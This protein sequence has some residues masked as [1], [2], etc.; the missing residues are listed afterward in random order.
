[1]RKP[2]RVSRT[3]RQK[4]RFSPLVLVGGLA[5]V[6]M[7]MA[8]GIGL[9]VSARLQTHAAAAA[10]VNVNCTLIVPR[11]PLTAQGLATPYRLVAT[12]PANGPCQ[13][14]NINATAFVQAAI[15]D[16]ATGQVSIYFPTIVDQGTQPTT[17]PVVPQLPAG[18]VVGLTIG[19]TGTNLTL[20]G[21]R[22]SLT[23]GRCVN[24][25]GN[26]IF[27]QPSYC[28]TPAFFRAANRA[29]RVGKLTPPALGTGQD[30][31]A[32]PTTRDF[33][34]ADQDPGDDRLQEQGLDTA[35]GC[36]PWLVPNLSAPGTTS[37]G[38]A[39]NELQASVFQARPV[40]L[41]PSNDPIDLVNNQPNLVKLDLYRLGLD[42]P[43]VRSLRQAN[44]TTYC[45]HFL[46]IAPQRIFLDQPLTSV[47]PTPN[48]TKATNLFTFL[49]QRFVAAF[50]AGGLNCTGLLGVQNP[51]QVT[52]DGNG[53]AIAATLTT[54]TAAQATGTPTSTTTPTTDPITTP[55]TTDTPSATATPDTPTTTDTP[56]STAT[57]TDTP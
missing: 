12:N 33:S 53:V 23:E 54:N 42:Q 16:P 7:L 24:G 27:G 26:S 19:F 31:L 40:G 45:Q 56:T 30:G 15:I 41:I 49:A 9:T 44:A 35:L 22:H 4:K 39:F 6:V 5:F 38:I 48:P 28:N 43:L 51:I 10:A 47:A 29:I 52:T 34:I 55:T 50:G 17:P 14:A 32:C 3:S 46:A 25:L 8:A 11:H 1:M 57:P 36:T 37:G 18:A 13:E 2:D 21:T 20:Q